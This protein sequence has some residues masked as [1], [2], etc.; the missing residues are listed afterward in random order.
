[1]DNHEL[2]SR[3]GVRSTLISTLRG[4]T[5]TDDISA[6]SVA[7]WSASLSSLARRPYEIA[8]SD[9]SALLAV[10]NFTL[11]SALEGGVA[12]ESMSGVLQAASAVASIQLRARAQSVSNATEVNNTASALVPIL[13]AYAALAASSMVLGQDQATA[14]FDQFRLVNSLQS[15]S[16][17]ETGAE[18]LVSVATTEY[19]KK[20]G[21]PVS[22]VTLTQLPGNTSRTTAVA[23]SVITVPAQLYASDTAVYDTSPIYLKIA[24]DA[25]EAPEA[26][27][28][29]LQFTFLHDASVR[30]RY[31]YDNVTSVCYGN[32][33]SEI[34]T[35]VCPGSMQTVSHNCTG[36]TGVTTSACPRLIPSCSRLNVASARLDQPPLCQ[37][38]S[39]NESATVCRC[40]LTFASATATD[41][42]LEVLTDV[43]DETGAANFAAV[44]IYTAES[45][46]STFT[47]ADDFASA[48]ALGQVLLVVYLIGSMWAAGFLILGV[49]VLQSSPWVRG[50]LGQKA[51]DKKVSPTG[52]TQDL[53][54]RARILGY[55]KEVIPQ[56][57]SDEKSRVGKVLS[58]LSAHHRYLTLF[59]LRNEDMSLYRKVIVLMK[60]LTVYTVQVFLLAVL[61]DLQ[62]AS[63]DGS[64]ENKTDMASCLD[65]KTIIDRSQSYCQWA[66]DAASSRYFCTYH[67]PHTSGWTF[68]YIFVFVS[69]ITSLVNIP[70]DYLFDICVA[71]FAS[72]VETA[73]LSNV[74]NSVIKRAS[75]TA[76]NVM[77]NARRLSV[78]ANAAA[79]PVLNQLH[80]AL[81]TTSTKKIKK[82]QILADINVSD[83]LRR[84]HSRVLEVM[85][86]LSIQAE[87]RMRD[88]DEVAQLVRGIAAK[89]FSSK[90]S[91][92]RLAGA[93]ISDDEDDGIELRHPQ[94]A[95]GREDQRGKSV[96]ELSR[97]C[98]DILTQRVLLPD[99]PQGLQ[100]YDAQWGIVRITAKPP[101]Y[102]VSHRAK[103][104]IR[105]SIREA[106]V[107]AEE[108]NAE[109]SRY[110]VQHAGLTVLH[111]FIQDILGRHTPAAKI[112]HSK[113]EENYAHLKAVTRFQKV[114]A[115]TA[116][117]ACNLFFVYYTLLKAY[118]KG[119]SW[120][121]AYVAACVVQ[122]IVEIT[123]NE[124]L[125]CVWLNYCV[126]SLVSSEVLRAVAIIRGIAE[127][128]TGDKSANSRM[129]RM[130]LNAAP[131]LFVSSRVAKENPDMLESAI[132][133]S[134]STHL[135]GELS[136]SWPHFAGALRRQREWDNALQGMERRNSL[137]EVLEW[138]QTIVMSVVTALVATF[139]WSGTLHFGYQRILIRVT[140]PVIFSGLLMLGYLATDSTTGLAALVLSLVA[141]VALVALWM[142]CH[143]RAENVIQAKIL[144]VD[145]VDALLEAEVRKLKTKAK[146]IDDSSSSSEGE[147]RP[148]EPEKDASSDSSTDRRR[149]KSSDLPRERSTRHIAGKRKG[150]RDRHRDRGRGE[151]K[152]SDTDIPKLSVSQLHQE[153]PSFSR[154]SA[155]ESRR[156][157]RKQRRHKKHRADND[158]LDD[159]SDEDS[160]LENLSATTSGPPVLY[161]GSTRRSQR[162]ASVGTTVLRKPIAEAR[163]T[164]VVESASRAS[165]ST[166]GG[167]HSVSDSSDS[168]SSS[169]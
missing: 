63:D 158:D 37:L 87:A 156:K 78:A 102:A 53:S 56:V 100:L 140:Q 88:R 64:C 40:N 6:Q 23:I 150:R 21:A 152:D 162:W 104:A 131:Y 145:D 1:M 49:C 137:L 68:I 24:S 46:G 153:S 14:I 144:P 71:P 112:F 117:V 103:Q 34:Y 132:V 4:V 95:G 69:V 61:Y 90:A 91:S 2:L 59:T 65:R 159:A 141:L 128:L 92:L 3:Q 22:S 129:N 135:P 51:I 52:T 108:I 55:L 27:L 125:E 28:A 124:T 32:A 45:F 44:S 123:L 30:R 26:F 79:Q 133:L 60:V 15:L 17:A 7:S 29:S 168:D 146:P 157:S 165:F 18:M 39:A 110:T 73:S 97:L 107:E 20:S 114:L 143:R 134:Y 116:I 163:R 105:A 106:Q 164:L 82:K 50:K 155:R 83:S 136:R 47:A 10:A 33:S 42:R 111:L 148:D 154:K 89:K 149:R 93:H 67:P 166:D 96:T 142:V 98:D 43:V 36:K 31:Q 113:F 74:R 138:T 86:R 77:Q 160:E 151:S 12:A 126:P 70:I 118:V 80:R 54:A 48:D 57:Y 161:V 8:S 75:I 122:V 76:A 139:Q 119:L 13:D 121:R 169:A 72:V 62:Y 115:F 41:R 84:N 38:L 130:F 81:A 120:Q 16:A 109:L 127:E 35:H 167:E 94:L 25:E 9:A 58:E 66:D 147:G 5:E 19:E 11:R 85:P 101:E 99:G